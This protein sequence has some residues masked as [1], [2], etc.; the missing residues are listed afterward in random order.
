[1]S[2]TQLQ[3]SQLEFGSMYAYSP[4][5]T[6]ASEKSSRSVMRALKDDM[7][8]SSPPLLT[9]QYISN[10]LLNTRKTL[11]FADFFEA[12][13]ILV[14][15][16]NSSLMRPG[17]LWV[18]ERLA[19][20]IQKNGLGTAVIPCLQRESPLRKSATSLAQNRPKA[21]EH[22]N[23]LGVQKMM[24][25]P[26]EIILVDDIITRGATILG[27]AN[28]LRSVYPNVKIR[29]F[30]AMRTISSPPFKDYYDPCIGTITLS[31]QDT[32]RSP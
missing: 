29:A 28:R 32:F 9:S 7:Y 6:S 23:S 20:A 11:P 30:A 16:P 14:P 24:S 5:G 1:M 22:Y 2:N 27:A 3:L 10:A 13:P 26:H 31:G 15:I 4:R 17:T 25:D 12:D 8:L 19:K 21:F 18:S